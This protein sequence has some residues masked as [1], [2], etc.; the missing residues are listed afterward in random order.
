MTAELYG[1]IATVTVAAL[2]LIKYWRKSGTVTEL[3]HAGM[4]RKLISVRET[5][6]AS[7][8]EMTDKYTKAIED[9]LEDERELRAE[10]ASLKG[11]IETVEKLMPDLLA[12]ASRVDSRIQEVRSSQVKPIAP[13]VERVEDRKKG[14]S[15]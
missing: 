5:A 11:K 15:K 8:K 10:I 6:D 12:I 7:L 1:P 2:G 3:A 4:V 14:D 9:R 13:G